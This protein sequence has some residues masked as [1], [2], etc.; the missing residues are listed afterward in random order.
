LA[1]AE[2]SINVTTS[3]SAAASGSSILFTPT[4]TFWIV[5]AEENKTHEAEA[6]PVAPDSCFWPGPK[7]T[8]AG[9][10]D[11]GHAAIS[12]AITSSASGLGNA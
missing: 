11:H 2:G 8:Y 1:A 10:R 4:F 12:A 9:N 3:A 5:T 6:V 7:R